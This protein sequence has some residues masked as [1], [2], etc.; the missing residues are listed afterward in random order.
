ADILIPRANGEV[1]PMFR[2]HMNDGQGG[3]SDAITGPL[4]TTVALNWRSEL[5]VGDLDGDGDGDVLIGGTGGAFWFENSG[6]EF[7]A[8]SRLYDSSVVQT[9][10]LV[11]L[12]Q[13]GDL[14]WIS[15]AS[16]G[17]TGLRLHEQ[18]TIGDVNDDGVFNSADLIVLFEVNVYEQG[19][20]ARSSF[21][22]GDFNGDGLFDSSDL[23]FA[24]QAGTYVV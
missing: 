17:R 15:L 24:M 3:F 8:G 6:T 14:D 9:L 5:E 18:R 1:G 19:I 13:D 20:T 2:W 22:T 4:A 12:D 10:H 7:A 16:R 21:N 23:V 11:D